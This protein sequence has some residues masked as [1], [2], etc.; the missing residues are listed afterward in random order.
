M[1]ED[2]EQE[3]L[4]VPIYEVTSLWNRAI[5]ISEQFD[6]HFASL[7]NEQLLGGRW[8]RPGLP[9]KTPLYDHHGGADGAGTQYGIEAPHFPAR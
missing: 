8:S 7:L 1:T 3:G 6:E 5:S 9:L 2:L 4:G